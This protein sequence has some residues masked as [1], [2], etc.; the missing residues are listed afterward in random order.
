[1]GML[2]QT[3]ADVTHAVRGPSPAKDAP[4]ARTIISH[5]EVE[6]APDDFDDIPTDL[7]SKSA[8]AN[9]VNDHTTADSEA[10]VNAKWPPLLTTR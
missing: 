2:R 3:V 7:P 5:R 9:G 10:E 1:M 8:F 4:P 6:D